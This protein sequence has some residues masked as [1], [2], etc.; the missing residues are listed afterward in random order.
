M[1]KRCLKGPGL[2]EESGGLRP[3]WGKR[4]SREVW[5]ETETG[6]GAAGAPSH[7]FGGKTFISMFVR[8]HSN[9]MTLLACGSKEGLTYNMEVGSGDD[10]KGS[11]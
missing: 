1:G 5:V 6:S 3:G 10:A 4:I 7:R 2:T 11:G 9:S 8:V